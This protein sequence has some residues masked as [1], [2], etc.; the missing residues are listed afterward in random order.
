MDA[1]EFRMRSLLSTL[2]EEEK[3]EK[4]DLEKFEACKKEI[5]GELIYLPPIQ[6][7][8]PQTILF[9]FEKK[10]TPRLSDTEEWLLQFFSALELSN[11]WV[12][13]LSLE[14]KTKKSEVAKSP[15]KADQTIIKWFEALVSWTIYLC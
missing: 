3:T 12:I 7:G 15:T 1:D 5:W 11:I 14:T 13:D 8:S 2:Q 6:R 4:S 9:L 10:D